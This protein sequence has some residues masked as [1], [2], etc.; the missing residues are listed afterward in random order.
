M[1]LE[2]VYFTTMNQSKWN[3]SVLRKYNS[4]SHKKILAHLKSELIKHP[5][6][7][8][9]KSLGRDETRKNN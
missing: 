4:T 8:T 9:D 1:F 6:P 3:M 5:L 2:A 7:R